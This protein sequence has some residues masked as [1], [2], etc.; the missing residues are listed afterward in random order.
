MAGP[1]AKLKTRSEEQET[2][3]R[4]GEVGL[5]GWAEMRRGRWVLKR[6]VRGLGER[7]VVVD[8]DMEMMVAAIFWIAGIAASLSV[9]I[10]F[11]GEM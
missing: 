11:L 3:R 8:P 2:E 5:V 6:G 10:F 7:G 1:A 9:Y 4:R